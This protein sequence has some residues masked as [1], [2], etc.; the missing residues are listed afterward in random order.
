MEGVRRVET[1]GGRGVET[2]GG[3]RVEAGGCGRVGVEECGERDGRIE[4]VVIKHC[5]TRKKSGV[6]NVEILS[7]GG[8]I[9]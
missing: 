3:G 7:F 5:G 8:M 4:K 9:F 1:E 6:A 2:K